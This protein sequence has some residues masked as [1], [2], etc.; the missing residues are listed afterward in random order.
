MIIEDPK[1]LSEFESLP[2]EAR[3]LVED[4]VDF[5]KNLYPKDKSVRKKRLTKLADEPFIGM[6]KDREDIRDSRGWVGDLRKR[7][8][9]FK[10]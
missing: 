8:W 6:W 1:I 3:K 10:K 4:F 7:E 9:E 2:P 5:L